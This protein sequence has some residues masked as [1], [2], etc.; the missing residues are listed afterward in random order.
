MASL[1]QLSVSMQQLASR[2][3]RRA[4]EIKR[5]VAAAILRNVVLATPVGNPTIWREPH[6]APKGYAGGRA[7]ANWLVGIGQTNTAVLEAEDA[8][9]EGTIS[10]GISLMVG[11]GAGVQIHLCNN[12]PYIIPLNEGHSHQAPAAFIE[13]AVQ[14]GG[15]ILRSEKV[16]EEGSPL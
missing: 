1:G 13:T 15:E 7:R 3:E 9:G 12:L 16:T 8:G 14:G 11:A 4:P 10:A 2:V 6:K 5:K